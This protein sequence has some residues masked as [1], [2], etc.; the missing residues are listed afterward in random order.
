MVSVRYTFVYEHKSRDLFIN[1]SV[2]NTFRYMFMSCLWLFVTKHETPNE[3]TKSHVTARLNR[4]SKA[5]TYRESLQLSSR[6]NATPSSWKISCSQFQPVRQLVRKRIARNLPYTGQLAL[7]MS[8]FTARDGLEHNKNF[9]TGESLNCICSID[10]I[11]TLYKIELIQKIL[12]LETG[13]GT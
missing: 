6:R 13:N 10:Y 12:F 5:S 9:Q 4:F 1:N 2:L 8:P 7:I 3:H 11:K